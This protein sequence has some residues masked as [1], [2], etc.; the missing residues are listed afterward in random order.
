MASGLILGIGGLL[1][2]AI[3]FLL[4]RRVGLCALLSLPLFWIMA[5]IGFAHLA[6]GFQWWT[7]GQIFVNS[8][9][10]R[11]WAV[12]GGLPFL[13]WLLAT[14][15]ILLF[16]IIYLRI[17]QKQT[18]SNLMIA[19]TA[20]LCMVIISYGYI[21][22]RN[23]EAA[24]PLPIHLA[25][26]QPGI[27]SFPRVLPITATN[28]FSRY[29]GRLSAVKANLLIIPGELVHKP[30]PLDDI[31]PSVIQSLIGSLGEDTNMISVV[32]LPLKE[33]N[34]A[35]HAA[36]VAFQQKKVVGI[37]RKE[38]LMPVSDYKPSGLFGSVFPSQ[39]YGTISPFTGDN[40]LFLPQ[41]HAG[42][43]I[44][45]EVFTPTSA[46]MGKKSGASFLILS[47]NDAAFTS[48]FISRENLRLTQ[49]RAVENRIWIIRG[50]KTGISA[51]INPQGDIV[52][53]LSHAQRG[54]LI[55]P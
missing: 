43:F 51:I 3:A 2:F 15:N 50:G 16:F 20:M 5:E 53:K 9:I 28:E 38:I 24:F 39:L 47:G 6:F 44:C 27:T 54:L 8:P 35:I 52:D 22:R 34:N 19:L 36:L 55:Y 45:N 42:A 33:K 40:G 1:A 14:F 30:I 17:T 31:N 25:I 37:Y 10:L 23:S 48:E 7:I 4:S 18:L 29:T 32:T 13:S 41:L 46:A 12:F 11:Q 49:L 26:F 21:L